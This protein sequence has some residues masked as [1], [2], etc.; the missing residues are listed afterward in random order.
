MSDDTT[1]S[2]LKLDP[3]LVD[4]VARG[5]CVLFFGADHPPATPGSPTRGQLAAALAERYPD[6]VGAG[7]SLAEAAQQ[8]VSRRNGDRN[9]L[10]TFLRER[11]TPAPPWSLT[12]LHRAIVALGFDAVVTAWYDDL[13]ERAFQDKGRRVARIISGA[14]AA[15]TG[16]SE[17]V[18]L[19][20]LL[21]DAAQPDSLVV[22]KK[23]LMK[24]EGHLARRLEDVR[25]FVR[26][27]PILFVGWDPG[28]EG[29]LRLYLAATEALGE[30]RRRNF[31]VWHHPQKRHIDEWAQENVAVV[32]AEPLAFL[33]ALAEAVRQRRAISKP[34]PRPFG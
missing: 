25:P 32:D 12:E 7:Q 24:V 6:E 9:T 18:I 29:L 30:N 4:N 14:D 31:I 17:D 33:R 8:L 2:Q 16:G 5:S 19:V 34:V 28:D 27:R 20:K 22:T 23:E 11:V 21:G 26:L 15:Y 13:M 1:A 3:D 10:I